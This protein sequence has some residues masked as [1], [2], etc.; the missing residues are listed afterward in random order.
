[1]LDYTTKDMSCNADISPFLPLALMKFIEFCK[2]GITLC[3][4]DA[5]VLIQLSDERFIQFS[6]TWVSFGILV[7][8]IGQ[9]NGKFRVIPNVPTWKDFIDISENGKIKLAKSVL[10][11]SKPRLDLEKAFNESKQNKSQTILSLVFIY[12]EIK[13]ILLV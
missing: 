3:S 4:L 2:F 8:V 1:M 12:A 6:G 9:C 13:T 5:H 11:A 7:N 10:K